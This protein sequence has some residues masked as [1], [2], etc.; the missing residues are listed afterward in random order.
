V[1]LAAVTMRDAYVASRP[2]AGAACWNV[3]PRALANMYW[4]IEAS[5]AGRDA[6]LVSTIGAAVATCGGTES[7]FAWTRDAL[8]CAAF[9][10]ATAFRR[11]LG[12]R[13]YDAVVSESRPLAY[14]CVGRGGL[15]ETI[16]D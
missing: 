10:R 13:V 5:C 15:G 3:V 7:P 14:T 16:L 1:S 8:E 6:D 2:L 4:V 11:G 12:D 9:H